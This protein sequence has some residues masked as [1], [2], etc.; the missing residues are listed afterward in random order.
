[1]R[2]L[3]PEVMPRAVLVHELAHQW[4]GA[5]VGSSDNEK[6][7]WLYEGLATYTESLFAEHEGRAMSTI[8]NT[9]ASR[10]PETTRPLDQ[11]DSID[12][13][14]DSVTYQRGALLYHALRLEIGDEPFF[15]TIKEFIQRNLHST[16]EIEDLQAIAEEITGDD[17]SK[18]FTS[19]V[20]GSTVP[21][22]PQTDG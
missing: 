9:L 18:F 14:L 8:S 15:T 19:W 7:N 22:L 20:T 12:H 6:Y 10:V 4:A 2:I 17:L 1:M 16:A 3:I 5:A 13:I 11:I 21:Q